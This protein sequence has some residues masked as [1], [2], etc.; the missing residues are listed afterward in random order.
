MK[1]I[2]L[3][4]DRKKVCHA[5]NR[6]SARPVE[7]LTGWMGP[8]CFSTGYHLNWLYLLLTPRVAQSVIAAAKAVDFCRLTRHSPTCT[9]LSFVTPSEVVQTCELKFT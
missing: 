9:T 5:G 3:S 2:W 6:R 7:L 4:E 8:G 1:R